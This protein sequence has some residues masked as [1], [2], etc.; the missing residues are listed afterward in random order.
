MDTKYSIKKKVLIAEDEKPLS[1]A[2]ALKLESEN[3][4]ID[5]AYDGDM[6]KEKITL[7]VYDLILMDLM[8]PKHDGFSVLADLKERKIKTPVVIMSNLSQDTDRNRATIAGASHYFV[9]AEV[10]LADIVDY[11]KKTLKI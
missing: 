7:N 2:L 8:M 6:V 3:I 4:E 9:K 5:V 10:K 1:K 11:V